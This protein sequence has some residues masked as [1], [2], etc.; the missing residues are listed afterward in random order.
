MILGRSILESNIKWT[1]FVFQKLPEEELTFE[2]MKKVLTEPPEVRKEAEAERRKQLSHTFRTATFSELVRRTQPKVNSETFPWRSVKRFLFFST[3]FCRTSWTRYSSRWL[4]TRTV[5][6]RKRTRRSRIFRHTNRTFQNCFT[7]EWYFHSALCARF[8]LLFIALC[9]FRGW[10][11]YSKSIF[12]SRW[13]T[14]Q[15]LGSCI[16][17]MILIF[18][19]EN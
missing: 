17:R 14:I 5:V 2:S 6:R 4:L 10:K 12:K 8:Q 15:S 1:N 3:M 11:W 19:V 18:L 16:Y 13:K 7:T 9:S